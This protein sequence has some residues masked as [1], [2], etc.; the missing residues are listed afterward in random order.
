MVK[1]GL[2]SKHAQ[3]VCVPEWCLGED[4]ASKDEPCGHMY[5]S[6]Q[7]LGKQRQQATTTFVQQTRHEDST[8]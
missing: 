7:V 6:Q 3:Y 4:R 8:K 5:K 1:T 2:S